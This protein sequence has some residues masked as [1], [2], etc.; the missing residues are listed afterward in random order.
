MWRRSV[1]ASSTG[2]GLLS[3]GR[4]LK[5]FYSVVPI[6]VALVLSGPASSLA[7]TGTAKPRTVIA[8]FHPKTK[9]FTAKAHPGRCNIS[10]YRGKE[11]VSVPV[12]GMKWGHW[13]ANPTRADFGVDMRDGTRA[14]VI[15]HRPITSDDGLAWY[16]R[17]VIV[18]PADGSGFILRLPI[19]VE[20]SLGR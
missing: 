13:G 4:S 18:F 17:V 2:F 11:R 14:R 16:S 19:C 9:R 10:G 5:L 7:D 8:C 20:H 3:P 15:A 12:T 6:G 1:A